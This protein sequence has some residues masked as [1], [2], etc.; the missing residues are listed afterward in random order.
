MKINQA[1][2]F[3]GGSGGSSGLGSATFYQIKK[4]HTPLLLMENAIAWLLSFINRLMEE[5][6]PLQKRIG[7]LSFTGNPIFA[8]CDH[9]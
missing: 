6:V 2:K 5:K 1:K 8:K 3:G 7:L 4:C 9:S